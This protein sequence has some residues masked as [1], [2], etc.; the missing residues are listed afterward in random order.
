[1]WLNFSTFYCHRPQLSSIDRMSKFTFIIKYLF[2]NIRYF[3]WML[4]DFLRLDQ[5]STTAR[6]KRQK[7]ERRYRKQGSN[8]WNKFLESHQSFWLLFRT[9]FSYPAAKAVSLSYPPETLTV[10]PVPY[11]GMQTT[12]T[13]KGGLFATKGTTTL[14]IKNALIYG[15]LL[16]VVKNQNLYS[17]LTAKN[18]PESY[19]PYKYRF[20][21]VGEKLLFFIEENFLERF[22]HPLKKRKRREH[23]FLEKCIYT[24]SVYG[25]GD[26]YY[27]FI[28]DILPG[29]LLSLE[30][31]PKNTEPSYTV[32]IP[33][34]MPT[35]TVDTIKRVCRHYNVEN[36]LELKSKH[37]VSCEE[38]V[39]TSYPSYLWDD[40]PDE[41]FSFS[42]T[43]LKKS[44]LL[45]KQ[46]YEVPSC[47]NLEGIV[48]ITRYQQATKSKTH[49][50]HVTNSPDL[51]AVI[52]QYGG[53]I[54]QTTEITQ[55][56]QQEIFSTAKT[57]VV[58]A[59][60]VLANVVYSPPGQNIVIVTA[61]ENN[62]ASIF[63]PLV[64]VFCKNVFYVLGESLPNEDIERWHWNVRINPVHLEQCLQAL[65]RE[66]KDYPTC[67]G[68]IT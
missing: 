68:W 9:L 23:V 32:L 60:A 3:F 12:M 15:K 49:S 62:D 51:Y 33:K 8:L 11:W 50:R 25:Y 48:Y 2:L 58:D 55:K 45:L 43:L 22:R 42:P 67:S 66:Q 47:D 52:N 40:L 17:P 38:V 21:N 20:S 16:G 54:L 30:S 19:A 63:L 27:H 35:P 37:R 26:N 57:I 4:P 7:I 64:Q 29:L 59:G 18:N 14:S 1:M 5:H 6:E 56:I 65:A 31:L 34:S 41:N 10:A 61:A 28:V 44:S 36:F 53:R 13:L 24:S 46:L 39:I